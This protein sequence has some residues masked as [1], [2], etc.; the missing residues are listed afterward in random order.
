MSSSVCR[1]TYQCRGRRLEDSEVHSSHGK[2]TTW[3]HQDARWSWRKCVF[4]FRVVVFD[5]PLTSLTKVNTCSWALRRC[6]VSQVPATLTVSSSSS[7]LLVF[8]QMCSQRK[9]LV[10]DSQTPAASPNTTPFILP[11][12]VV[13]PL[14][15]CTPAVLLW[16]FNLSCLHCLLKHSQWWS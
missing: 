14:V 7:P 15:S 8:L 9:R 12:P 5:L 13:P 10:S 2:T 4:L 3:C 11:A 6:D 1:E 16:Y